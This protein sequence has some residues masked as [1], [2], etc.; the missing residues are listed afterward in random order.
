MIFATPVNG[1]IIASAKQE[2][3]DGQGMRHVWRGT[4]VH[5]GFSRGNLSETDSLICLDV[6]GITIF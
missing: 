4:E 3:W 1:S 5:R 2:E 6:D